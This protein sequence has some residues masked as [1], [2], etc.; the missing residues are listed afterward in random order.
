MQ[1][2]LLNLKGEE[3]REWHNLYGM[4]FH[5]ATAEGQIRRNQPVEDVRPFVLSRAFFA[6]SQQYGAIWTGDNTAEWSHLEVAAPVLLSLNSAG[7]TFV[8]ADV[9]GFFGNPDA[10][11]FTRWYQAGAYQPFFRGHAHHDT[12]R[13]EPWMYD[14][15]TLVRLRRAAMARYALL[16]FWYTVFQEAETTG[17]PVMRMM[18]MQYPKTEGLF[19]IDDQYLIGSDLLVKPVVSAGVTETQVLFPTDDIWY[20]AESLDLVSSTVKAESIKSIKVS[21]PIDTIPVFQRG[22]SI[23][24]RKLRLRRSSML[25]KKDPYTL[26]VALDHSKKAAGHLYMDDEETFG[27]KRMEFANVTITAD[28]SSK[29]ATLGNAVTVGSG[30]AKQEHSLMSQRMIERIIIMGVTTSPKAIKV[31]VKDLV[32]RFSSKSRIVVIRKPE[33]SAMSEWTVNLHM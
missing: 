21:S 18:W 15:E 19:G 14:E 17:M 26:Y 4:L 28:F 11:L 32:F 25:M 10:E 3:H 29:Q 27:Y 1:K 22:G 13:R 6:G 20:D 5:R 30:W 16:P 9:G 24:A 23:I 31:E 2:D 33:L 8:G 12:K 7:I